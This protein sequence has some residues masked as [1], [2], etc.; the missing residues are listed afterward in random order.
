MKRTT[1]LAALAALLALSGCAR[2]HG[3]QRDIS[4]TFDENDKTTQ[5]REITTELSGTA[6]F[7]SAQ[8]LSKF[9]A[10]QTD[11]SQAFNGTGINQHGA[12][13]TVATIDAL[14]K[15]LGAAGVKGATGGF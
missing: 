10:S 7:S 1:K 5:K 9:S 3:E 14:T 13:N 8:N 15:L 4:I 12:T 6:W 2:F 11:K